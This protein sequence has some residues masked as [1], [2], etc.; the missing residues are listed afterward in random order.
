MNKGYLYVTAFLVGALVMFFYMKGCDSPPLHSLQDSL[1]RE[2]NLNDTLK[3]ENTKVIKKSDSMLF[4]NVKDSLSYRKIIDSQS[5]VI[6]VLQG[7]FKVSRDSIFSL[8]GQLKEYYEAK[9]T[10]ALLRSYM[11]LREELNEADGLLFTIQIARDSLQNTAQNEGG[12]LNGL[13]AQLKG[14]ISTLNGLLIQCTDNA[15]SLA[16]NGNTAIK[17][18]RAANMWGRISTVLAAILGVILLVAK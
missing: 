6:A 14:Q 2:Q 12:R 4:K 15:S 5:R 13:I 11:E 18:A 3:L 10:V 8:Y 7:K 17:K 9:D 16:K 1:N